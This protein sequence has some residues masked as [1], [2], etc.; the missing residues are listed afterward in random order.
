MAR[1][2]GDQGPAAHLEDCPTFA[3]LEHLSHNSQFRRQEP[4]WLFW[5]YVK[6]L[7]KTRFHKLHG[8]VA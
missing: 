4:V 1:L 3:R 5:P 7:S 2:D 6:S 8:R